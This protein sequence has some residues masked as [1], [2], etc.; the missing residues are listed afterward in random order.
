LSVTD[1]DSMPVLRACEERGIAFVPF[2]PLGSAFR[3]S[4]VL[5]HAGVVAT[6]KRLGAT[7]AQVALA[8]I[9][10][11]AP[12]TLLIPGTS[13]RTHLEENLA[14]A[15]VTLDEEALAALG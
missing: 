15:D 3:G 12:N 2:F 10:A 4:P 6:A 1:R 11:L 8:W 13:S 5:A 14:T 7:P 9:L